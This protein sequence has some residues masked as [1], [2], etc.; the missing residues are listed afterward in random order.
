MDASARSIARLAINVAA[1]VTGSW[2]SS[3][4]AEPP[5]GSPCP[6]RDRDL[7]K[8]AGVKREYAGGF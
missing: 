8:G 6:E 4:T 5:I 1:T 3:R 7:P 2:T